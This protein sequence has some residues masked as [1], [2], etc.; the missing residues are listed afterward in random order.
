MHVVC[1]SEVAVASELKVSKQKNVSE[2]YVITKSVFCKS[3]TD[4]P[5]SVICV[6]KKGVDV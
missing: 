5:I 1:V 2:R 4:V 3:A 6:G